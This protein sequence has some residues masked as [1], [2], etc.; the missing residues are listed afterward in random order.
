L[1]LVMTQLNGQA[2]ILRNPCNAGRNWLKVDTPVLGTRVQI[3]KQVRHATT[4]VGYASS[5][6][7]PLHFGLGAERNV[8]VEATFPDGRRK[9]VQ[10]TA[11]RTL[12]LLP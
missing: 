12:K 9:Q 3:G 2:R 7:G 1:D 4:S 10:T 5:Y 8:T 11:N 6:A